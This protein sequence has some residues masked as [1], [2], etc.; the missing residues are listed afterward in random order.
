MTL[1]RGY[2]V[3][4]LGLSVYSRS[5]AEIEAA[6][7]LRDKLMAAIFSAWRTRKPLYEKSQSHIL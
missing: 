6:E 4:A 2:A 3:L 7:P 1:E 5:H